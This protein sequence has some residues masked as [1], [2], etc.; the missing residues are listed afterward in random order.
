MVIRFVFDFN[1]F[2]R[3][4]SKMSPVEQPRSKLA[5]PVELSRVFDRVC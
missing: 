1:G 2:K 5:N 3:S 4:R